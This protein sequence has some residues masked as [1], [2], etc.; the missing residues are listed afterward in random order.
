MNPDLQHHDPQVQDVP[1]TMVDCF[2]T[3]TV[4]VDGKYVVIEN[5]PAQLWVETGEF[6]FA[7]DTVDKIQDLVWHQRQPQRVVEAVVLAFPAPEPTQ[8]S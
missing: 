3:H 2:I 5:V 6:F 4:E 1:E 7:E 8:H